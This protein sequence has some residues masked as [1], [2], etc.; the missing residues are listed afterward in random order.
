MAGYIK[1][2]ATVFLMLMLV[3]ATEMGPKMVEGRTCESPSQRFKGLCFRKGNCA[4]ICKS[5]G[6]R[7]GHCRG[8]RRRCFCTRHC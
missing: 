6:F 5:E 8:F 7:S 1:L 4:T 3:F 2:F